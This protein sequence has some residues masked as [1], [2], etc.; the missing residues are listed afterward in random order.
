MTRLPSTMG[1]L[2]QPQPFVPGAMGGYVPMTWQASATTPQHPPAPFRPMYMQPAAF[3][4]HHNLSVQWLPAPALPMGVPSPAS[5]AQSPNGVAREAE[6][7][8]GPTTRGP[9]LR[10]LVT[11]LLSP[12]SGGGSRPSSN[13]GQPPATALPAPAY[14]WMTPQS[15]RFSYSGASGP[16]GV[17]YMPAAMAPAAHAGLGAGGS[18][19]WWSPGAQL[20]G[21]FHAGHGAAA[22]TSGPLMLPFGGAATWSAAPQEFHRARTSDLAAAARAGGAAADGVGV[23]SPLGLGAAWQP[24]QQRQVAP[25]P[26]VGMAGASL[27]AAATGSPRHAAATI[28]AAGAAGRVP[29]QQPL[30]QAPTAS[31][32]QPSLSLAPAPAPAGILPLHGPMAVP[33]GGGVGLG[34]GAPTG[35]G[36][37]VMMSHNPMFQPAGVGAAQQLGAAPAPT[38]A[39]SGAGRATALQSHPLA[40]FS[41]APAAASGTVGAAAAVPAE[42]GEAIPVSTLI[43][44][45]AL[46]AAMKDMVHLKEVSRARKAQRE[47]ASQ[48]GAAG[49][50]GAGT[51]SGVAASRAS[52]EQLPVPDPATLAGV[53]FA[54][55]LESGGSTPGASPSVQRSG[56]SAM[57]GAGALTLPVPPLAQA[58]AAHAS[59]GGSRLRP[60]ATGP[61]S[62]SAAG[63]GQPVES[64]RP[65][66]G[67]LGSAGGGGIVSEQAAGRGAAERP[68]VPTVS[69]GTGAAGDAADATASSLAAATAAAQLLLEQLQTRARPGHRR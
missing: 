5:H 46:L 43:F 8:A 38:A 13:G 58:A 35:S 57:G 53:G 52:V 68:A 30:Q 12:S 21:G 64:P 65:H 48:A 36:L 42:G 55:G 19:V 41:A 1:P 50:A 28:A 39:A 31:A 11:N 7:P 32:W 16:M 44:H 3:A 59:G 37:A 69:S 49:D 6:P 62:A 45:T 20:H 14:T 66:A 51:G 2:G 18:G 54:T 29:L 9:A 56:N 17:T 26:P 25:L 15:G 60:V 67:G 33:H 40:G 27:P 23:P 24:A 34:A 10:R 63:T 22:Q 47:A 61:A 4:Q